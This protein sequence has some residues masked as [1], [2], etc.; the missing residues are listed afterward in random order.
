MEVW[1]AR[2]FC[3]DAARAVV[4]SYRTLAFIAAFIVVV[5]PLE[6]LGLRTHLVFLRSAVSTCSPF[7][8]KLGIKSRSTH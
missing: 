3:G 6:K 2:S 4:A 7:N 5:T 8:K 1:N